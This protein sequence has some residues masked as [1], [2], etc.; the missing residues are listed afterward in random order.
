MDLTI[1]GSGTCVPTKRRSSSCYF[2]RIGDQNILLDLGFG[3][4]RRMLDAGVDYRDIDTVVI[5]HTHLDHIG[6]LGPLVMALRYTPG[7]RRTRPLTLIGP[8]GFAS[9]LR[10]YAAL[11]AR[12]F[13]KEDGFPIRIIELS[14]DSAAFDTWRV[15]AFPMKHSV[16]A[17][18]Y[19]IEAGTRV[20]AYSGDTG[21]CDAVTPLLHEASL[22][23]LECSLPDD[24]AIDDHLTPSRAGRLAALAGPER[25]LL[26]HFYPMMDDIDV[27]AECGRYFKGNIFRAEDLDH[28]AI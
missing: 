25:L 11:A 28:Y 20:L 22:A 18:G 4:M 27:V 10:D 1:L 7:F 3:S 26:T 2:L 6:D 14:G 8:A 9:Y 24:L 19:R 16:A 21:E 17:N 15:T 5:T 12:W 13:F 23:I